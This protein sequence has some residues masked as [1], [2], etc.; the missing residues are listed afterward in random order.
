LSWSGPSCCQAVGSAEPCLCAVRLT[1]RLTRDRPL[2]RPTGRLTSVR[3]SEPG[4]EL[5]RLDRQTAPTSGPRSLRVLRAPFAR[6][7]PT[8]QRARRAPRTIS[9]RSPPDDPGPPVDRF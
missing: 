1:P 9:N 6:M 5:R 2:T 4:P 7:T 3:R 8:A